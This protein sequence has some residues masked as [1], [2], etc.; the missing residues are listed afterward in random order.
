MTPRDPFESW[1]AERRNAPATD[2]FSDRVMAA[3]VAQNLRKRP[4]RRPG[5]RALSAFSLAACVSLVAAGHALLVG[6]LL[7]A[8]AGVAN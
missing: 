7:F 4:E 3:V 8:L 6:T 2:G 5:S 1:K